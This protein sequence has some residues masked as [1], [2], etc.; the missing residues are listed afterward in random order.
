MNKHKGTAVLAGLLLLLVLVPGAMAGGKKFGKEDSRK[1]RTWIDRTAGTVLGRA[2]ERN[3]GLCWPTLDRN[4]QPLE[5]YDFHNGTPGVC[6]FLLKAYAA[7]GNSEYLKSAKKGLDYLLVQGKRDDQGYYIFDKLNGLFVGNAGR[8][9]LFLYAYRVTKEKKY[10]EIAEQL[11][12]RIMAVPDIGDGSGTD[13][14]TGVSG[15]GLFLLK[16]HEV[17]NDPAC[18]KGAERLGDLIVE[19]AEPQGNGVRWNSGGPGPESRY[20]SGYAHGGPGRG[21]FLE[22][23]YRASGKETYRECADKAMAHVVDTAIAE[24]GYLKWAREEV[25]AR[26]KFPSQWCHGAPGMNAFF[27]ARHARTKD[28]KYMELAA[29]NTL[30]LLDQ[31]VNIRK[32]PCVCHGVSGNTA[33]LYADFLATGNRT[34]YDETLKGLALLGPIF[35]GPETGKND[36]SYHNGLAGVG[37]FLI[38]LYSNGKLPMAGGLGFGDDF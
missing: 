30:Y 29:K 22:R 27:F 13:I 38:F 35:Q 26:D 34:Y 15:T 9:H 5:S 14:F 32:S 2:S 1:L 24:K 12:A 21:C 16:L 18:L 19:R 36:C 4:G 25:L 20:Y 28:K 8:A 7:T 6:Y 3:G 23:L 11:A 33:A 37:D 17:T 10:L 31:G